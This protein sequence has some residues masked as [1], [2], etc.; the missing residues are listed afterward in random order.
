MV[1][2]SCG[3]GSKKPDLDAG[4]QSCLGLVSL[5]FLVCRVD[6][7]NSCTTELLDPQP[8]QNLSLKLEHQ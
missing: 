6:N 8:L 7:T 4:C 3:G 2:L 1:R 5:G